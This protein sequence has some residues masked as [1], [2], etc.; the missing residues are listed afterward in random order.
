MAEGEKG[1]ND[2]KLQ[3]SK[4]QEFTPTSEPLKKD[5]INSSGH[6]KTLIWKF[7]RRKSTAKEEPGTK[8]SIAASN[9]KLVSPSE[10]TLPMNF[11]IISSLRKSFSHGQKSNGNVIKRDKIKNLGVCDSLIHNIP[12]KPLSVLQIDELLKS[13]SLEEAYPNLLSLRLEFQHEQETQGDESCQVNLSHKEKDLSLLY[14][15]LRNKVSNIVRHSVSLPLNNKKL[16]SYTASIIQEEEKRERDVGRMGEWRDIWRAAV[17]EGV[18]DTLSGVP[19]DSHEQNPSWLVVHLGLLGKRIVE[20][21]ENVKSELVNLY[22]TNFNVFETYSS[23]CHEF[24]GEHLK[25]LLGK[26]TELNDFSVMLDF[27]INCYCSET[28]LGSPSLQPEMDEKNATP[29]S[30]VLLDQIKKEYCDCLQKDIQTSLDNIIKLEQEEIW[31]VKGIPKGMEDGI[32]P[33]SEIHMNICRM[34]ARYA[35]NAWKVDVKL[36]ER[37]VCICLETLKPFP[38]RFKEEFFKQSSSLLCSD[39]LDCC[40]WAEYHIAYINSFST[41]R[42]NM[43]GYQGTC[44]DQVEHLEC[45]MDGLVLRLRQALLEQ[46][47]VEIKPYMNSMMTKKWLNTDNDFKELINRIQIYS[48]YKKSMRPLPAQSFAN[49]V[50]YH[51]VKEYISQ[52]L[53]N[54]YSCKGRKNEDAA[55]KIRQQWEELKSLFCEMESTLDWLHPLGDQLSKIIEQKNGRDIKNLLKPLVENYPDIR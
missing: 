44:P 24:V 35:E 27:S 13:D 30:D 3:E 16:L 53:K 45:E 32:F 5:E 40:L 55:A 51:F 2:H 11:G 22:P 38:E 8:C 49:E 36:K 9:T 4:C 47:R 41:L 10:T 23:S 33:T 14:E 28:I 54:K 29:L 37:V 18:M 50:H 48:G 42:D 31:N 25:G 43:N 19:L 21:L 52:L 15:T 34:I 12:P 39:L 46:F 1:V 6:L 20:L 7:P 26:V 17:Q